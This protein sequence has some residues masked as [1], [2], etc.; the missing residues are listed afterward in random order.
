MP[1]PERLTQPNEKRGAC[2]TGKATALPHNR[3]TTQY[4]LGELLHCDTFGPIQPSS[5]SEAWYFT[6]LMEHHT[7]LLF[8]FF[9]KSISRYA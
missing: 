2:P 5:L 6:L 9:R 7:H 3:S 4:D 1:S 8:L